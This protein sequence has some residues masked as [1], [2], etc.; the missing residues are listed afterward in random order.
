MS[1]DDI[2]DFDC[3]KCCCTFLFDRC[4]LREDDFLPSLIDIDNTN[5]KWLPDKFVQMLENALCICSFDTWIV[6]RSEL[7]DWDESL[8]A[9]KIDEKS[10]LV[11]FIWNNSDDLLSVEVR[12]ELLNKLR[13]TRLAKRKVDEARVGIFTDNDRLYTSPWDDR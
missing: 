13:L 9:I 12:M 5:M 10:S 2:S 11:C 6:L 4:F 3:E 8:D 1:F 7:R